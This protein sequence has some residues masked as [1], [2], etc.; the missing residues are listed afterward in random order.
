MSKSIFVIGAGGV[1]GSVL[2]KQLADF[3]FD[4]NL[5]VRPSVGQSVFSKN[6]YKPDLI[7]NLAYE[8]STEDTLFLDNF[9]GHV[10]DTTAKYRTHPDWFYGLPNMPE[11]AKNIEGA[12]RVSNPGCFSQGGIILLYPLIK[13]HILDCHSFVSLQAIG[14]YSSAGKPAYA[15]VA[16]GSY[17]SHIHS[18]TK[19]HPH[20]AEIQIHSQFRGL[21]DFTPVSANFERGTFVKM[22]IPQQTA[23]VPEL[24]Y[25]YNKYY[26]QS[27]I[28]IKKFPSKLALDS[29]NGIEGATLYI[30]N[31]DTHGCI[32]IAVHFDNLLK[33]AAST[34]FKNTCLMLGAKG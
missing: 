30:S 22:A 17:H 25:V 11:Y 2:C 21:L 9:D 7:I 8:L 26:A 31:E 19:P 18:L 14:G 20:K 13:E 16:E 28:T 34:A 4:L 33:G 23:L 6:V 5:G 32:N 3:G 1:F 10:L 29:Y 24:E 27:D 12:K 15:L